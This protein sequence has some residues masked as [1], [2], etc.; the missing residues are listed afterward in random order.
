LARERDQGLNPENVKGWYQVIK[1]H[2]VDK[3]IREEDCYSMDESGTTMGNHMREHVVGRKGHK[4][5]HHQG[6]RDRENVTAIITIC[7]DGTTLRPTL[8]YK[9]KNIMKHWTDNN[10]SGA[11]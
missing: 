8:I 5:H 11:S 10:I 6:G 2:I 7:A 1:T 4:V 3:D 9:G